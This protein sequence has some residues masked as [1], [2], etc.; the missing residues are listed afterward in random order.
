MHQRWRWDQGRLA[1]FR[2][3][4]LKAIANSLLELEGI[5]IN[6]PGGD[7]LRDELEKN[8]GL[9]F[10]PNSYR[11]W[12]NYKRVFECSFLA[13]NVDEHLYV[14]DF[15][16][17]L[18]SA[19]E[20]FDADEFLTLFIPRFRFPFPAF[21]DYHQSNNPIYPF[22]AVLKY[23]LSNF[24]SGK[25]NSISLEDVFSFIVGNSC[26]GFEPV[27]HYST[28]TATGYQP[29]GDENRQV[30][31]MLIF[32]SQLSILKWYN[33]ALFL[34][35]TVK[36]YEDYNGFQHLITPVFKEPKASREEEYL[37]ITSLTNEIFYPFKLKSRETPTDELFVEGKRSR[38]THIKI[39]RSP[40]L[41]RLFFNQFP[42]TI[43]NMCTCDTRHKYPWTDNI[44]EVHHILPLSSAL[45]ITGEGTSLNDVVGLCPNCH[46][47]VHAYYRIY[48]NDHNLEDFR[49]KEEAAEVYQQAKDSV[50]A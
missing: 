1:Y 46:K 6:Q 30:R 42:E 39:E 5:L 17:R 18:A 43:C 34:D 15:C 23:L 31:E 2:F 26:T 37:S 13:T 49:T 44:L 45:L 29:A 19:N 4:N 9:P 3:E 48:L 14:T 24:L 47:S 33:G 22:C 8:T 16:K 35:I 50:V 25:G 36:D 21:T 7:P 12:R 32:I 10:A 27:E 41:R 28:L 40:L 11:V 20:G 38:V